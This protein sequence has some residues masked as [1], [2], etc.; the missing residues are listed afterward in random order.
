[1]WYKIKRFCIEKWK[2]FVLEWIF[3]WIVIKNYWCDI[4]SEKNRNVLMLIG[5]RKYKKVKKE[6]EGHEQYPALLCNVPMLGKQCH[7]ALVSLAKRYSTWPNGWAGCQLRAPPSIKWCY[8][9]P[10]HTLGMA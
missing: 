4:K 1:M 2:K 10:S 3:I 7:Y 5:I 9:S 6:E 8:I